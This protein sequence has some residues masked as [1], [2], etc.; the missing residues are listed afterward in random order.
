MQL[1]LAA[2]SMIYVDIF[3]THNTLPSLDEVVDKAEKETI[4]D[5]SFD[6]Q[7]SVDHETGVIAATA[8]K[9]AVK[10]S[11]SVQLRQ[12]EAQP[13]DNAAENQ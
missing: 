13:L 9:G 6:I 3:L 8:K 10:A 12:P 4:G 11:G 2:C 1:A 5:G 7:Y